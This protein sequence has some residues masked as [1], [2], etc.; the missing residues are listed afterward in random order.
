MIHRLIPVAMTCVVACGGSDAHRTSTPAAWA[1]SSKLDDQTR[2]GIEAFFAYGDKLP[3]EILTERPFSADEKR[4]LGKA[5]VV[6]ESD[7][8]VLATPRQVEML[9]KHD[10]IHKIA[11]ERLADADSSAVWKERVD[12]PTMRAWLQNPCWIMGNL[13]V[14][15]PLAPA[16]LDALGRL[17]V[18]AT[19]DSP[20]EQA[21]ELT[22]GAVVLREALPH[23][24]SLPFVVRF[25]VEPRFEPN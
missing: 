12:P 22:R 6:V 7:R 8:R 21:G 23:L 17:G 16:Q 19:F 2:K 3:F 15:V 4:E 13:T 24:V 25:A 9:V 5:G 1:S 11:C 14:T 10:A 20:N 18:K